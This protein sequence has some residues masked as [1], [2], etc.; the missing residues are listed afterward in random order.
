MKLKRDNN[1]TINKTP[2]AIP[3][4]VLL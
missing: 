2:I 3:V 4:K 1:R